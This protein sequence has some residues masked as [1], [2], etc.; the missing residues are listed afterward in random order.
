MSFL[1]QINSKINLPHETTA[2]RF[3]GQDFLAS[4][5]HWISCLSVPLQLKNSF[6]IC[7]EDVICNDE[8]VDPL[9]GK[10]Q[11]HAYFIIYGKIIAKK[12]EIKFPNDRINI[13][14]FFEKKLIARNAYSLLIQLFIAWFHDKTN[15]K[16]MFYEWMFLYFWN[17][18]VCF[19]WLLIAYRTNQFICVRNKT[20]DE[21]IYQT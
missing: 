16:R 4:F 19:W 9:E 3:E 21:K 10:I 6:N 15:I 11:P 1:F 20:F 18:S 12:E 17:Y 2:T 8:A 5:G 14:W 13:T 7:F